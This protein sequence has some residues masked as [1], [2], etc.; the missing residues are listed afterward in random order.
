[1]NRKLHFG[2]MV[3]VCLI[4]VAVILT[5]PALGVNLSDGAWYLLFL[6]CPAT[7]LLMMRYMHGLG[8]TKIH[9]ESYLFVRTRTSTRT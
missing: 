6:L 3:L 9:E 7:H 5:L 4:P 2:L 1:M 8:H